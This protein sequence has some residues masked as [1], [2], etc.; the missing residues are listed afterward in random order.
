VLCSPDNQALT[1]EAEAYD[2]LVGSLTPLEVADVAVA[3]VVAGDTPAWLLSLAGEWNR[4]K[5]QHTGGALWLSEASAIA[6]G[7]SGSPVV[8]EDGAAIGVVCIG[9]TPSLRESGQTQML[10]APRAGRIR[11]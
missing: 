3:A 6:G 10:F 7:M 2:A 9:D 5:V 11:G 4:C 1:E 8:V